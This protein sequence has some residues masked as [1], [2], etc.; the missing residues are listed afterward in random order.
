MSRDY[1]PFLEDIRN[2]GEKVLRYTAGLTFEQFLADER[3]FDAVLHNL[4]II[5]EA[6][7]QVPQ[8]FRDRCPEI[9]W[10]KIG[11][12]R[13]VVIHHYFAVDEQIVWD[14]VETKLPEL[15]DALKRVDPQ[16]PPQP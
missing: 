8:E 5:G 13:D 6:A 9:E 15:L 4:A 7:K 16:D 14:I 12:F 2:A 11:R 3:T 1:R 10:R